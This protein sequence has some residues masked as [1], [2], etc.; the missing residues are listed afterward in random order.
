MSDLFHFIPSFQISINLIENLI[1]GSLLLI[2]L[3]VAIKIFQSKS[4][5]KRSKIIGMAISLMGIVA[6]LLTP[7]PISVNQQNAN[8]SPVVIGSCNTIMY[9]NSDGKSVV[10]KPTGGENEK[11]VSLEEWLVGWGDN[12]NG[13]DEYT[14]KE[15]NE[16]ALNNRIVFNSIRDSVIGHE[17]NYV[18]ARE[19]SI[20]NKT[21]KCEWSGNVIKVE[22]GKTY[23]VRLYV[24]N[25]NPKALKAIAEDVAVRFIISNPVR[26]AKKDIALDG[27]DEGYYGVAVHGMIY[28]SN[29]EPSE[30]WDGVKFVANK[31]FKMKY[32]PGTAILENNV[33]RGG[34][35]TLGDE[36]VNDKWVFIGYEKL[37]GKLPGCYQYVAYVSII[38]M[39]VFE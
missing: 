32:V 33:A 2:F 26:V 29:A 11:V 27:F 17:F 9:M 24:H 31:P 15:I 14:I 28:S 23:R 10:E 7:N 36:I 4:E 25:N 5:K 37:D 18:G 35:F 38:V 39:P 1:R 8:Q 19:N 30:Y 6:S 13:R 21:K 20:E 12:A 34:A 3:Y 16:G 22:K